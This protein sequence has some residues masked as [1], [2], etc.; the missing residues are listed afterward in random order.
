MSLGNFT[1]LNDFVERTG[2]GNAGFY[3]ATGGSH[4]LHEA[5]VVFDGVTGF[6]WSDNADNLGF[7]HLGGQDSHDISAF[8]GLGII[9]E[10]V[11]ACLESGAISESDLG[12]FGGDF[13]DYALVLGAMGDDDV[14]A[15]GRVLTDGSSGVNRLTHPF[16]DCQFD[17]ALGVGLDFFHGLIHRLGPG[18]IIDSARQDKGDFDFV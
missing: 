5:F 11:G 1:S 14:K 15:L 8:L 2:I 12:E 13:L 16:A 9:G 4:A 17:F 18:H 3:V 6:N 10:D 7:G